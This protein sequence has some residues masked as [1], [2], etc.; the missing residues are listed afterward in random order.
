M[1]PVTAAGRERA[2]AANDGNSRRGAVELKTVPLAVRILFV[3]RKRF[4]RVA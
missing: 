4:T 2:A 1:L 3:H